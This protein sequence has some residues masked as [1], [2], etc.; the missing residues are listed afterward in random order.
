LPTRALVTDMNQV[1]G[2]TA[3][4]ALEVHEAIEFLAGTRRE[5]RLLELTLALAAQMLC[6]AGLHGTADAAREAARRALD[7]G[8]AAERFARMVAGLGGPRD[9]LAD[10][11]LATAPLQR[12]LPAPHEGVLA[13]MDTRAIGLAIVA[14]GGGRRRG[15]DRI[16]ARV[17][18]SDVRPLGSRLARGEP[19]L[20]VHA[21]DADTMEAAQRDLGAAF[22]IRDE[23]A[24]AAPLVHATLGA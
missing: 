2:L 10:A 8:R 23:P 11:G 15:G 7:D 19:L 22:D 21:A 18:L 1:L 4:N 13:G 24:P 3:G 20:R 16:D 6:G 17:G 12:D 5:P 14:L 9:V